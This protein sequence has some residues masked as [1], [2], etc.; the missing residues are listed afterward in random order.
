MVPILDQN[1]RKRNTKPYSRAQDHALVGHTPWE[2]TWRLSAL[3]GHHIHRWCLL[4][5]A[6]LMISPWQDFKNTE[7]KPVENVESF[8]PHNDQSS[9]SSD[10]TSTPFG[11]SKHRSVACIK[12]GYNGNSS[13]LAV[14]CWEEYGMYQNYAE[15][16]SIKYVWY[17]VLKWKWCN[18]SNNIFQDLWVI[19]KFCL[20]IKI[21]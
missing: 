20:P 10:S 13:I 19:I 11:S 15:I 9:E 3:L 12:D 21:K 18:V 17:R 6:L 8:L 2:E 16:L 1:G 7:G 5:S 14:A 4:I